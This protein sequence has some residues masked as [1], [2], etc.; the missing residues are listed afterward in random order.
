MA[1]QCFCGCGRKVPFGRKR[2]T[3]MLGTRLSEDIALFEGAVERTPDPKHDA[4]LRRLITTGIPL[5]D[6]LQAVLHGTLDRDDYPRKEGERWLQEA[7]SHR[8]RL[9]IEATRGDFA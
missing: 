2:I 1:K 8:T 5:R 9:A 7:N 3:N 6:K 4:D